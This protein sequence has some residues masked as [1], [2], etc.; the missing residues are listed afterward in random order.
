[1][2]L[3]AVPQ[4]YDF[5]LSTRRFRA[6]GADL[7]NVWHEEGLHRVVGG[8]EVRI[9]AAPGGVAVEPFDGV[10]EAEVRQLLGL[11]FELGPFRLFAAGEPIL[12]PLEER[13]R[14][15][16]PV[17]APT[18][19]EMLVTSITAQQISLY[20]AFAIRNRLIERYGERGVHAYAFPPQERVAAASEEDLLALGFSRRKAEYVLALARGALD[21][22]GVHA[23]PDDE[24]RARI[25]AVRGFGEWT[26]DWFLARYLARPR[27]WPAGYLALRK[28]VSAFY[29]DGRPLTTEEVRALAVRFDPFQNLTAHYLLA[30]LLAGN[31]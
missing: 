20:A 29:G 16:R 10:V 24:V 17:L 21:L 2:A 4:P 31:P 26:A 11:R 5:V 12:R 23:L 8:R 30:G 13:L 3:V 9:V 27:A 7:A 6:F 25:V 22:D 18:A 19:W 28:A 14:G 15:F 1:M